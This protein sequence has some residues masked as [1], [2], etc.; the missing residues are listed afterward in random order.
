MVNA[1]LLAEAATLTIDDAQ[2][3][4]VGAPD[5]IKLLVTGPPGSGK[6]LAL[7]AR[8]ARLCSERRV[9]VICSHSASTDAFREALRDLRAPDRI[10]VATLEEHLSLWMRA[11]YVA[12]GVSR[13]L[14]IG[15]ETATRQIIES[16]A[17]GLYDLSWAMFRDAGVNLDLPFFNRPAKF[18]DEA[19][20]L[21]CLLRRTMVP[22]E[23]FEQAC[24]LGL[25]AFYGTGV[26]NALV[27]CRETALID[28]T[29]RRGRE[30]LSVRAEVLVEQRRAESAVALVLSQLYREYLAASRNTAVWSAEDVIDAG[31]RWLST[32]ARAVGVISADICAIVVD[33]AEDAEPAVRALLDL[34]QRAGMS[35]VTIAGCE[36]AAIDGIAG[37]RS[38]LDPAAAQ[39]HIT[40][41]ARSGMP[42]TWDGRR[43]ADENEEADSLSAHVADLLRAGV[44]AHDVALLSRSDDAA[45]IYA[46]LLARRGLPVSAPRRRFERAA[47]IA[48]LLALAAA[49]DDPYDHAHLLRVLS[50]PVVGLSDAS[51]WALCRDPEDTLQLS[52]DVG[53]REQHRNATPQA[54]RTSL[55]H[56]VFDGHVDH[57]LPEATRDVVQGFRRA[58]TAWRAEITALSPPLA[59]GALAQ[60]AGFRADWADAPDFARE[61]LSDDAQR[62]VEAA[63]DLC[64]ARPGCTLG[65]V[66]RALETGEAAIR[67]AKRVEHAVECTSIV[68]AK[69]R[70]WKHVVVAGLAQERFP[71]IYMP[72]GM[73]FSRKYGLIV[74]DNVAGGAAQTAKF[75]WYYAKFDAK[76]RYLAEEGRALRYGLSRARETAVATGY[77]MPPRRA[78]AEDLLA[79]VLP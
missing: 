11:N 7:A 3:R 25:G 78:A 37:R 24:A 48:D 4:V 27:R 12:A 54:R 46:T 15:T 5:G 67:P 31:L 1:S 68:E 34:F 66:V 33:D 53:A 35:A 69:G 40:L 22:P 6:T 56:N 29:S 42:R 14:K 43:F 52:L 39:M 2:R 57:L 36:E 60:S 50:S 10:R 77:G 72:R 65:E 19:A 51:L 55:A 8:A 63:A 41:P 76:S 61:R 13:D 23:A 30:A 64:A 74:R 58:A 44:E 32:D 38:A 17:S 26:E 75:A 71:R 79:G 70:R 62:L 45:A 49:L 28:R 16:A 73:A 18:L 20:S 59:L 47:H 9:L 21:F